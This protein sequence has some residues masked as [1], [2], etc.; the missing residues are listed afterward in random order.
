ML[1][2]LLRLICFVMIALPSLLLVEASSAAE[3]TVIQLDRFDEQHNGSI[4]VD[5]GMGHNL[6]PDGP[7]LCNLLL[8]GTIQRGDLDRLKALIGAQREKAFASSPR[9]CLNSPG[10]AYREGLAIASYLMKQS[11]GTA[12]PRG[13]ECYSA[14]AIV[15]MGGTF[16]WKGELNRYL[17]AQ[18]VLGF[19][20]PYVPDS[21]NKNRVMVDE[22]EIRTAF[23][24]GIKAMLAFM[25]LQRVPVIVVHSLHA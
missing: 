9:L 11:I 1:P 8:E 14:C 23:S 22:G 10:G 15:F 2:R 13:A 18:A 17:H 6:R 5:I 24:E 7:I 16:P 25:Q 12:I 20:A 4:D 3:I 21:N 19:H